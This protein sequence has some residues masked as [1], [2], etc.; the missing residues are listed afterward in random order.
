[1]KTLREAF[2]H[3]MSMISK[4]GPKNHKYFKENDDDGRQINGIRMVW[5]IHNIHIICF[6]LSSYTFLYLFFII[7]FYIKGRWWS[8]MCPNIRMIIYIL[9]SFYYIVATHH[10][11]HV[12]SIVEYLF[13]VYTTKFL[14]GRRRQYDENDREYYP[15]IMHI[16]TCGTQLFALTI[17][18]ILHIFF[19]FK[20]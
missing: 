20:I 2:V 11:P 18:L 5:E 1:M 3:S 9:F 14:L 17:I 12:L 7:S 4:Y 15:I 16:D 8:A 6:H 10:P 13:C 19:I